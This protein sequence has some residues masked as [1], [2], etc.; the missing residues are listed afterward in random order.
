M[1][2]VNKVAIA[3]TLAQLLHPE[4][5]VVLAETI[6]RHTQRLYRLLDPKKVDAKLYEKLALAEEN[7][8]PRRSNSSINWD[9]DDLQTAF[10]SAGLNVEIQT[11]Q[12]STQMHITQT[13][14]NRLF[15]RNATRPS[16]RDLLANSL[17]EEDLTVV[18]QLFTQYLLNQTV[19]WESTIAYVVAQGSGR[20]EKQ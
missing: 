14:L 9:A 11:E 3:H 7:I 17:Q 6:P 1:H 16:Y 4:G 20:R 19:T 15:A 5:M 13:F 12:N 2:E 10:E 8:Y 18:Q